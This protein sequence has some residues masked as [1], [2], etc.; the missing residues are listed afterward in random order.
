MGQRLPRLFIGSSS[1]GKKV[2]DAVG[3]LLADDADVL[4]W[5][6]AFQL[7]ETF[8]GSLFE[9]LDRSD[10]S[11][12]IMTPD[13][14][15]KSRRV[16]SPSPRDNVVFEFGLF[17][18]RIGLNRCCGVH[19]QG[20]KIPSDLW[21]VTT[22]TY[23]PENSQG[24]TAAVR[25]A[26]NKIRKRIETLGIRAEANQNRAD[27]CS[28]I[29]GFWWEHIEPVRKSALGFLEITADG[30]TGEVRIRGLAHR[31]NGKRVADW[32]TEGCGINLQERKLFYV[33]QGR[34]LDRTAG[35]FEGFGDFSFSEANGPFQRGHGIFAELAT[36][37][38]HQTRKRAAKITR[39]TLNDVETMQSG[40]RERI[41]KLIQAALKRT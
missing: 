27:F 7:G 36:A 35:Q 2:A 25:P 10:F 15:T 20:V 29:A 41:T 18:G 39:C 19:P 4:V 16:E 26:C 32:W 17:V 3:E 9:Q 23:R 37:D 8:T 30:A 33:W 14:I 11:V 1:E 24:L 22:G 38:L 13:D 12:L 31:P 6:D 40:D 34:Y 5:P 21:G 28:R